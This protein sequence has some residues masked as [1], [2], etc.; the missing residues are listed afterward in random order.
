LTKK[1]LSINSTNR[2]STGRIMTQITKQAREAGYDAYMAYG[3]G[4]EPFDEKSIKI[5][6]KVDIYWHGLVTRVTGKHGFSSKK[7]TKSFLEKVDEIEPDLIH[8]HNIHGYY[9]N[10]ELLFRYIKE[11]RIPVIWTLHDCWPFTGHCAHFDYV[12][13][14]KW[15]TGCYKCP[16]LDT[17]PRS[18]FVDH[19]EQSYRKKKELFENVENMTLVT[20]SK[21]LKDLVGESF[22]RRYQTLIINNG[23]D[24]EVFSP[25]ACKKSSFGI[26]EGKFVILG[27]AAHFTPRK[28]LKYFLE[29]ADKLDENTVI[30]LIGL[31]KKQLRSLPKNITGIERTENIERLVEAYSIADVFVNPTLE[32]TFPTTNLEALACGTPVI[33]FRTGGSPESID[34]KTGIV[35]EKD[36][37]DGLLNA[38]KSIKSKGKEYYAKSCRKQVIGNFDSNDRF[39]EYIEKVYRKALRNS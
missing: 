39:R 11:K 4:D 36:D 38:I 37:T 26:G 16:Q 3:R 30:F 34:D 17:Y 32:D 28:G 33:T 6:R 5:G 29:I 21:W 35:A 20:P 19:S 25:K 12:G 1:I 13:C 15:K 22:L 8:L 31:N 18:L 27:V 2:G 7:A 14:N 10:I 24:T 23:V 9:L